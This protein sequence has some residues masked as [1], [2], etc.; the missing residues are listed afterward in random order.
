[1]I[2]S[3]RMI[4]AWHVPYMGEMGNAYSDLVKIPKIKRG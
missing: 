4:W 1:M 3:G 2:K